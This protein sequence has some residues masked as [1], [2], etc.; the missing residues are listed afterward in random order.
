[1]SPWSMGSEA[2]EAHRAME[3]GRVI[4][5][6]RGKYGRPIGRR[7]LQTMEILERLG[8]ATYAQ[9]AAQMQDGCARENVSKY[10]A[11]SVEY[12]LA[13]RVDVNPYRYRP[14]ADWRHWLTERPQERPEPVKR[15]PTCVWDLGAA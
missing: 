4:E 5:T 11:R 2:L 13:E 9:V 8:E 15:P 1:M 6:P 14:V 12:G 7:V 3:R 10:M